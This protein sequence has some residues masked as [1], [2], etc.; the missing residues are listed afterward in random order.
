LKAPTNGYLLDPNLIDV[1]PVSLLAD[2][3]DLPILRSLLGS[4]EVLRA[5]QFRTKELQ[6]RYTLV[7]AALRLLLGRYL[8]ENPAALKFTTSQKGKPRLQGARPPWF[9]LSHSDGI[10][11]IGV[12]AACEIGID[13]ETIKPLP[14]MI[15]VAKR[16]FCSEE[17][18]D[19]MSIQPEDRCKAFYTCWTRKEAYVKA[20]GG[21]LQTRLDDFRVSLRPSERARLLHI[22]GSATRAAQWTL[23]SIDSLE[24]SIGAL[25]HPGPPLHLRLMPLL[26]AGQ[27]R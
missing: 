16:F 6:Q 24:S 9:N 7:H 2:Q 11:L 1:W 18:E 26:S 23:H 25:A 13:I 3:S 4:E 10:A 15:D 22:G 14:D 19:L 17:A 5:D 27:L 8:N 20:T 12:T 21:G